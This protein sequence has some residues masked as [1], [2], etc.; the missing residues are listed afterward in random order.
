[1]NPQTFTWLDRVTRAAWPARGLADFT[2]RGRID[3]TVASG[4]PATRVLSLALA[5]CVSLASVVVAAEGSSPSAT[6]FPDPLPSTSNALREPPNGGAGVN[7]LRPGRKIS[8]SSRGKTGVVPQEVVPRAAAS[9]SDA[10]AVDRKNGPIAP[11]TDVPRAKGTATDAAMLK[12]L[13]PPTAAPAPIPAAPADEAV[14]IN[15]TGTSTQATVAASDVGVAQ[16]S[17]ATQPATSVEA[18]AP[19]AEPTPAQGVERESRV[20]APRRDSAIAPAAPPAASA[21]EPQNDQRVAP[22]PIPNATA[23]RQVSFE[24]TGESQRRTAAPAVTRV[25]FEEAGLDWQGIGT[26]KS[27]EPSG[28]SKPA[29]EQPIMPPA[30]L[31]QQQ[32]PLMHTPAIEP[33]PPLIPQIATWPTTPGLFRLVNEQEPIAPGDKDDPNAPPDD[34]NKKKEEQKFGRAPEVNTMQF[35]RTQD[36]LLKEGEW[37]FDTGFA[38]VNFDNPFPAGVAGPGPNGELVGVLPAHLRRRLIY[39]PLAFRYGWNKNLQV[40]GTLPI[41]FSN[42]QTS[43]LGNSIERNSGGF[44]D[45]TGGAT[46]HLFPAQDDMADILGTLSVTAPTGQYTTPAFD[47]VP[48]SALGQGFWAIAGQLTFINQY[49]P[50]VVFYGVGLRHLFERE[51]NDILFAAGEQFSYMMGVG[52]AVNDKVT[53]SCTMQ[54]FY[55]TNFLVRN[56]V[57]PGSNVEP[58]SLRFAATMDRRCKIIEPFVTI[59]ATEYAPAFSLG[60]TWTYY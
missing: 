35:L 14:P 57:V 25:G 56:Q 11:Q 12:S 46:L 39:T 3:S 28:A 36:V 47:V 54:A 30:P 24:S 23:E 18:V 34:P 53:L 1:M 10:V 19:R 41:G 9:R 4:H 20:V 50:I 37:Q 59:G 7:K 13:H 42:T 55:I 22:I 60:I 45:F 32:R 31:N 49:D 8:E 5:V 29:A 2:V 15:K 52:F 51:F 16:A 38:Y 27:K 26:G 6:D 17:R 58:V 21:A 40:F 44:G 43:T 48:G 33:L